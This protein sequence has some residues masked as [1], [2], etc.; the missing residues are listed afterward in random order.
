[1]HS[2]WLTVQEVADYLKL[3][4]TKVYQYVQHGQIPGYKVGG[5]WRFQRSEIDE[6]I[7]SG[8]SD[9]NQLETESP[10]FSTGHP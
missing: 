5:Q 1:M 4:K 9:F 2:E 10:S 7:R 3:G 8:K 6:W